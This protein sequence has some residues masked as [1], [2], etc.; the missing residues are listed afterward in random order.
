[1]SRQYGINCSCPASVNDNILGS[2]DDSLDYLKSS[3]FSYDHPKVDRKHMEC[4]IRHLGYI[5]H[6]DVKVPSGSHPVC[7]RMSIFGL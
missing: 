7:S 1:M 2:W 3:R 5:P 4:V 6:A